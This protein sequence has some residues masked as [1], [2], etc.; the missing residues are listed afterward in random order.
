MAQRLSRWPAI[1]AGREAAASGV[2]KSTPPEILNLSPHP[3]HQRLAM[4]LTEHD[5]PTG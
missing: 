5:G 3:V 4:V 1:E 2:E